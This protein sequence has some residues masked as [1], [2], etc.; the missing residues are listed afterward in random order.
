M[1][2]NGGLICCLVQYDPLYMG[3]IIYEGCCA[4]DGVLV[5][6]AVQGR[7]IGRKWRDEGFLHGSDE[8]GR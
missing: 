2:N 6:G 8:K 1:V 4:G 5:R 3:L 7:E